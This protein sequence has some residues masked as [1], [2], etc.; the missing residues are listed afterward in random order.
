[1]IKEA[2]AEDYTPDLCEQG[3]GHSSRGQGQ[4][5]RTVQ[6]NG[7]EMGL[8]TNAHA[9]RTAMQEPPNRVALYLDAGG[10][11]RLERAPE[12]FMRDCT[13]GPD[14]QACRQDRRDAIT[15]EVAHEGIEQAKD[16]MEEAM[17]TGNLKDM[18]A[19]LTGNPI[20]A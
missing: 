11:S 2:A 15:L 12:G 19:N 1:M 7:D 5:G 20:A 17:K 4:R 14:S 13:Q 8:A 18:I 10:P 16:Y 6:A 3:H 9:S